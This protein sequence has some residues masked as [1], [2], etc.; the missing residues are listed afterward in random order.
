MD[1]PSARWTNEN[2]EK[3]TG[4]IGVFLKASAPKLRTWKGR[5]MTTKRD[6]TEHDASVPFKCPVMFR[7]NGTNRA[8]RKPHSI[9]EPQ[10]RQTA[11]D[12]RPQPGDAT[13]PES[14]TARR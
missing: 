6:W 11:N 1:S 10:L 3:L 2:Y 5:T 9:V 8:R 7:L 12:N 14:P 4:A 13:A